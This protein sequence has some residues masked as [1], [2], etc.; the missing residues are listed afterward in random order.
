MKVP[1]LEAGGANWVIYKDRFLWSI[2]AR[3]LL[4]HIDGSEREPICLVKP[5]YTS[6]VDTSGNDTGIMVQTPFTA[7]EVKK[8]NK[9][10][11]ELK[12]WKQGEAVVKQ[13]I[14]TTISDSLFMKSRGKGTALEIWESLNGDFQNKSWM[15]S[16]D[17][18]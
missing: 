8:I 2:D 5:S 10:K 17:L 18:R 13:Q 16:V 1:K 14:A 15:V 9:W 6:K 3:I 4:E 11:V 7:D 12:E